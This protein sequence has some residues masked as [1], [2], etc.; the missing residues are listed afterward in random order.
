[1]RSCLFFAVLVV[2]APTARAQAVRQYEA[3]FTNSPPTIDG[4]AAASEWSSA[5]TATGDFRLLRTDDPGTPDSQNNR[6]QALWNNTGL[7]LLLQSNSAGWSANPGSNDI[8]SGVDFNST[9]LNLYF[10]PNKDGGKNYPTDPPV[11]PY[12]QVSGYQVAF[13]QWQGTSSYMN[14]VNS[15]LGGIYTEAHVD[16]LFGNNARGELK[17]S[18]GA[19]NNFGVDFNGEKILGSNFAI[20]QNNTLDGGLA[21]IFIPW[22]FFNAWLPNDINNPALSPANDVSGLYNPSSPEVGDIWFVNVA[23]ITSDLSNFLPVWNYSTSPFFA[24]HPHGELKF[25]EAPEPALL[26]WPLWAMAGAF[27]MRLRPRGRARIAGIHQVVLRKE[28]SATQ[29]VEM[30][31][32]L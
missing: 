22:S 9:N 16:S 28:P 21:E 27:A 23:R 10:D 11:L 24:S 1:M 7:F 5:N 2:F 4:V 12:D 3:R 25:V 31:Q 32:V 29:R 14:G 26:S 20:A 15:A 18:Q 30:M 13:N 19:H 8:N 17:N 6:W